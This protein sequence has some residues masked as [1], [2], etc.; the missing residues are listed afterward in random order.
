VGYYPSKTNRLNTFQV[1]ISDGLDKEVGIGSNV[2]FCYVDM[3]WTTGGASGGMHGFG[4]SGATVGVNR[5]IENDYIQ[6][7]VF[8]DTGSH[9]DGPSSMKD[10]VDFLDFKG[11]DIIIDSQKKGICFQATGINAPPVSSDFPRNNSIIIPCG[12]NADLTVMFASPE[13]NQRI[14]VTPSG[15]PLGMIINQDISAAGDVVKV[16]IHWEPDYSTQNGTFEV[17]F[18][19]EDDYKIPANITEVLT[20]DVSTCHVPEPDIPIMCVNST[21]LGCQGKNGPFCTPYRSPEHCYADESFPLLITNRRI[22]SFENPRMAE[23]EGF[24]F[25]LLE[26]KA[27]QHA[28]SARQG[29]P[30]PNL[31]CCVSETSDLEDVCFA[32]GHSIPTAFTIRETKGH[33]GKNIFVFPYGFGGIDLISGQVKNLEDVQKALGPNIDKVLVEEFIDGSEFGSIPSLPTEYKFHMFNGTIGAIDVVHNKGTTCSCY[34][35]VD[36]EWNRLD[37]N[38]CFFPQPAFGLDADGDKCYDIDWDYGKNHPL[39][40][41]E[42]DLCGQLEHPDPCVFTNLK[43]LAREI[44]EVLGVYMRIDFFVNGSGMIF[45]QEFTSNHAGGLRHCASKYNEE[46]GCVDS[47]FLG[48]LWKEKSGGTI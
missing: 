24:W 20:I 33:S 1:V 29:Y 14:F 34:A 44:S 8:N 19:V 7:G 9:Y 39:K 25:H 27:A 32:Q 26:D 43:A 11:S 40:F 17:S 42:Q 46:T 15:M 18:F 31:Y 35:V 5:G 36:E 38:G 22:Q 4:G 45:V 2:C 12:S 23:Y 48:K 3:D 30:I 10:G 37:K 41:K 28:F 13:L 21:T 47:C 16:H 6:I